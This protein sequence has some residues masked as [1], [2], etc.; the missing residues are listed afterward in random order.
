[1]QPLPVIDRP[2]WL[3]HIS[4]ARRWNQTIAGATPTCS[5]HLNTTTAFPRSWKNAIENVFGHAFRNKPGGV[6]AYSAGR[7]G[8]APAVEHLALMAVEADVVPMRNAVL[9][10]TVHAAFTGGS[11]PTDRGI[12]PPPGARAGRSSSAWAAS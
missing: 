7:V 9:I 4:P 12:L 2:A 3:R 10:P 6:V 11:D 5:S 1:M 8:G